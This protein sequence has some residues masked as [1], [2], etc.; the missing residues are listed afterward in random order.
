[1]VSIS[2]E[3]YKAAIEALNICERMI[4]DQEFRYIKKEREIFNDFAALATIEK[5][6]E[7]KLKVIDVH[8]E[9]SLKITK[10]QQRGGPYEPIQAYFHEKIKQVRNE[11]DQLYF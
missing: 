8:V 5:E 1:M 7:M 9:F 3:F 2:Y 4:N 11:L 6:Q 10:L